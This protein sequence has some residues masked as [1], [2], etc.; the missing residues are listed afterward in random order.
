H[1]HLK[2]TIFPYTTLFRSKESKLGAKKYVYSDLNFILLQQIIER[3]YRQP[4][5][6]LLQKYFLDPMELNSLTYN[7]LTKMD[8]SKIAPTEIDRKSTRLNSSHVKISY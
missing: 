2:S 3:K 6:Q 4:L 8:V 5:E 7:P 1:R